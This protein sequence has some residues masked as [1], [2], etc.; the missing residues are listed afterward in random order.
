MKKV[1][2]IGSG[3]YVP[4]D[5]LARDLL[6]ADKIIA[7]DGGMNFLRELN[8]EPDVF[9]GDQDSTRENILDT[10]D[11]IGMEVIKFKAEKDKTD[12][13]LAIDYV[14][15][16]NFDEVIIYGSTGTRLDHSFANILL[17]RKLMVN[18]I[19]AKILDLNNEIY[20][21][22]D[23]LLLDKNEKKYISVVPITNDGVV[24]SLFGFK[25]PL[26]KY[27]IGFSETIGVSNEILDERAKVKIHSGEA[28]VF[29]S[30]D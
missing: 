27:L 26:D 21:V 25:Y 17:L 2:I 30:K 7:V 18:K 9:L 6:W 19:K 16:N 5:E 29:V 1:I 20:L 23:V 24:V 4:M 22:D 15:E 8:I 10:I 3:Q 12:M 14:V 28:L 11:E 13:E